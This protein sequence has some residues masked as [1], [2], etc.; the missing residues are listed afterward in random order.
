MEGL[1]CDRCKGRGMIHE[2][3][4]SPGTPELTRTIDGECPDCGGFGRYGQVQI[5]ELDLA[6]CPWCGRGYEPSV[7]PDQCPHCKG[8]IL[9]TQAI[10]IASPAEQ[11]EG[12]KFDAGKA[13]WLLMPW[14][15]L[16]SV[17]RVLQY[18]ER[19]YGRDNWRKVE[20]HRY[21]KAAFRHLIAYAKDPSAKDPD[22]GE[23][24]LSHLVCCALF[25][26]ELD[27]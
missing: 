9:R 19:T 14:E 12:R 16:G 26:L 4:E 2:V 15:A 1:M 25:L 22:T 3:R 20:K 17:V 5:K 23:S 21:V 24:H 6:K 7:Y 27:K 18:G 10:P 11:Q 13:D 8:R